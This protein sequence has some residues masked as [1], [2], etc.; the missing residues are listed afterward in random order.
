MTLRE[1]QSLLV[2]LLQ[3]LLE[4][5]HSHGY[6]FT[7]G[8]AYRHP[9][10][11]QANAAAGIGIAKSLHCERLAIDLNLFRHGEYLTTTEA[12]RPLGEYWESLHPEA[13]WGGRFSDGNHFS[14]EWQGRK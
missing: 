14:V 1:K 2:R 13:R 3:Q 10:Q 11:A 8:D 5:G 7:L 4:F 12:Y 6:E 9:L